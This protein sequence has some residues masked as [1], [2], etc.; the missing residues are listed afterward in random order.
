MSNFI[1]H[2]NYVKGILYDLL[3]NGNVVTSGEI[4]LYLIFFKVGH[5]LVFCSVSFTRPESL[6]CIYISR[7]TSREIKYD[8]LLLRFTWASF[9][10]SVV[11]NPFQLPRCNSLQQ[12]AYVSKQCVHVYIGGAYTLM[13]CF[14]TIE[15]TAH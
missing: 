13:T 1:R 12:V 14:I 3:W 8:K 5:H 10:Y 4:E 11:L 9:I 2:G 7:P 15:I 6:Y